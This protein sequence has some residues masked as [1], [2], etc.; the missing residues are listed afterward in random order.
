MSWEYHRFII[1]GHAIYII[2]AVHFLIWRNFKTP[3]C[4]FNKG[5]E[6]KKE[7]IA[8]TDKGVYFTYI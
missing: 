4:S 3:L 5:P 8:I 1:F 7:K 6:C 2:H